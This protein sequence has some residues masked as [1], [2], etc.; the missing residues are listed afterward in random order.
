MDR[1]YINIYLLLFIIS[2]SQ[3]MLLFAMAKLQLAYIGC[4]WETVGDDNFFFPN[5]SLLG[6]T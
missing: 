1:R 2:L 3:G 6:K 5:G 4:H